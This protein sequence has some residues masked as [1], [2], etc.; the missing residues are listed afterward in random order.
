MKSTNSA[1]TAVI[2]DSQIDT[3]RADSSQSASG[4]A[5]E[6][7]AANR[8]RDQVGE[9][10]ALQKLVERQRNAE[11]SL[12]L[13]QRLKNNKAVQVIGT[14]ILSILLAWGLWE[15]AILVAGLPPALLPGPVTVA[16]DL[17]TGLVAVPLE[18]GLLSRS[19]YI[20]P[21]LETLSVVTRGYL[22]GAVIGILIAS[23]MASWN[24]LD[25][26]LLP[27]LTAV[28]SMP[29]IGFAPLF[30][31]WFGFD[32]T[33]EVMMT[34]V[35]VVFPVMISTRGGFASVSDGRKMLARS[36]SA[37]KWRTLRKILIP[38]ALPQMMTGLELGVVYALLGAVAAEF[39]AGSSGLGARIIIFQ[40]LQNIGGIFSI[41]LLLALTGFVLHRIVQF[42][43]HKLVF[44]HS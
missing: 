16:R 18:S 29:L 22:Q 7:A 33:A 41:L 24:F 9:S 43:H 14:G 34:T 42:I 44:W 4:K 38:S 15:I 1:E 40:S 11:H 3:E 6:S 28:Q 37:T 5:A 26:L 39:L 8:R 19:G 13:W 35:I 25:R 32:G 10:T 30:V 17:W 27:I 31:I 20:L 2:T 21:W 23:L 12:G 36:F